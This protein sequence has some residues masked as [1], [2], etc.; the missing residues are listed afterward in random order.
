M[1]DTNTIDPSTL[2]AHTLKQIKGVVESYPVVTT[3][4]PYHDLND[5]RRGKR[6][7]YTT[8]AATIDEW[9]GE[10]NS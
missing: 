10:N 3:E 8:I 2:D 5:Y 4:T 9:L 7:A 1:D 6:D